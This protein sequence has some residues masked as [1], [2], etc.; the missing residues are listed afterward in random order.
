MVAA[1]NVTAK[2]SASLLQNLMSL[3]DETTGIAR[4]NFED[5]TG[6]TLDIPE[7]RLGE[8]YR[9]HTCEFCM[10]AKASPESHRDCIRN[11][12]AANR[13]AIW[14]RK[15][16][17]G[18]CHLGMTDLVKPLVLEGHVLG[19]FYYGSFV[20]SGTED[21]AREKIRKYCAKTGFAEAPFL[22]ELNR[23]RV[24]T[25]ES[26]AKCWARLDTV[27]DLTAR[28]VESIG[29]PMERYQT[30]SGSQ[31]TAWNVAIPRIVMGALKHI[32]RNYGEALRLYD[33]ADAQRCNPDYLSRLFKQVVGMGI[34]DYLQR[35]R[36]E[37]A[38]HLLNAERFS[39]GEIG[40]MV[41]FSDQSHFGKVFR[42]YV[43]TSPKEYR[44]LLGTDKAG[45]VKLGCFEYSNLCSF[46][47]QLAERDSAEL[48]EAI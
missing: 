40:Y 4:I 39:T 26:L 35:V 36:V 27:A 17:V 41:G 37:H 42:R 9:T 34:L 29:V 16:F 38:R 18:Q 1:N 43:G 12:M 23:A 7:L 45:A 19:V 44:K 21:R 2:Q 20:L 15:G 30:R 32:H 33:I 5:L 14:R 22:A 10:Y 11:K 48:T 3:V 25:N 47:P 46:N 6:L 31:F 24:L 13:I 8:Q 28:I